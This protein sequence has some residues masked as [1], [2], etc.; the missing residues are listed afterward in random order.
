[1][2][3]PAAQMTAFMPLGPTIA[4]SIVIMAGGFAA[5]YWAQRQA[6]RI[7]LSRVIVVTCW[8][9]AMLYLAASAYG[10]T[11][12]QRVV[13]GIWLGAAIFTAVFTLLPRIRQLRA[14]IRTS[15]MP[16]TR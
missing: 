8:N 1:M 7:A 10:P 14:E 6:N 12:P 9:S 2:A 15:S 13:S 4:A 16:R 3:V 5:L 11:F